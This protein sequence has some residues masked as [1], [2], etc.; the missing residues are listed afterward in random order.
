MHYMFKKTL[1]M[2]VLA[3]VLTPIWSCAEQPSLTLNEAQDDT[4]L[5]RLDRMDIFDIQW[6][7]DPRIS[8]DGEKIVY[9]RNGMDIMEDRRT[10]TL[11][12]IKPDGSGH[13]KL[14]DREVD[15][16]SPRWSPDGSRIAFTSSHEK[17]GSQI[18]VYWV[19]ESKVSRITQ[20]DN[21]PGSLSWSPDG[22]YIAFSKHVDESEPRLVD[23]PDAPEG[24]EWHDPP[25]VEDRLN[26]E[27]DGSGTMPY[28]YS[29]LFVVSAE[30]GAKRQITSGD[31]HHSGKPEWTPDGE[32]L[33]FS[34]NR[35]EDWE[36][37][38][39]N[40]EIYSADIQSKEITQLTDRYG[41]NDTP[42]V[43]PDG[44]TIAYLGY[45]DQI[46]TY[47]TTNLYMM[48]IDGSNDRE[49]ET[50][51]DRSF[52]NIRWDEDGY[53][54]YMVYEDEGVNQLSHTDPNGNVSEVARQLGGTT[55]GRPYTGAPH[56]SV[57]ENGMI[58]Y[59]RTSE[60]YPAELAVKQKGGDEDRITDLN[61][62]LLNNRK[63]GEVQEVW[64]ES[65]EDGF[66]IQGWIM[67][68]PDYDPDR[69]YPLLV[70]LHGGP[71]NSYGPNFSPTLQLYAADDMIVFYPNFRGSTGYGEDFGNELYHEFSGAEYQD[72]IDGVDMMVDEG[73][74]AEDSLY[75]TG[76]SAGGTSTAWIVGQTDRF[77]AA[78]VQKPVINWISKTLAADNYYA[79]FDHRYPGQPWENPMD[80]WEVSPIS[81]VGNVETPTMLLVGDDD[82]RTP[83][84]EAR[85]FYHALKLRDIETIYVEIKGSP[86]GLTNHPTHFMAKV[87][88][89]LAWFRK[90]RD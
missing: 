66:D 64:Y 1:L 21:S 73:H 53:G 20:L 57:A 89:V 13:V 34:A 23:P 5:P 50:G 70:E 79:Y 7:S 60:T 56:F 61:A 83:Y 31:Y 39:R 46:Q 27:A 48:D 65:S 19:E 45:E 51:L 68:P 76:G 84:W 12:M 10:S 72:I 59:N 32:K 14:T 40:S 74:V 9:V 30:G 28:G 15:E 81:L 36:H 3:F 78:V 43:S 8:P 55:I 67:T 85:Q 71:I 54:I 82:L 86:H 35:H 52:D 24:A 88:H 25:R 41:P 6:V 33:I 16:S 58:A 90:Y 62:D 42:R 37:E 63:L 80:Y 26:H 69:E 11:W 44:E 87:D 4:D 77:N 18:Y 49:I 2:G 75:V 47:Q 17:H 22:E 38:F 29:H